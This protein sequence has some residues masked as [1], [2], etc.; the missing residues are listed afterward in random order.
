M[1]TAL[2][3]PSPTC[4]VKYDGVGNIIS[5]PTRTNGTRTLSYFA[6]GQVK[7]ITD[8]NGNDANFRY[9]AFGAVQQLVLTGNTPDTRH[10]Q[11]FGGLIT[12]RDEVVGGTRKSV[13]TRSI[14][15]PGVIATRHGPTA[16]RGRSRSA[17]DA[18][19]A[20]SPTRTAPSFRTSSY[21]PYGE[22]N[23]TGAQPGA[24]TYTSAQWN[25]GDALAA[26]GLSQLGARIYDPVIG[27]FLSRDPLIIPRTAAT[28]NPYAFAMNDPVN[29]SDP[30]GLDFTLPRDPDNP[31]SYRWP[32]PGET[33][34]IHDKRDDLFDPGFDVDKEIYAMTDGLWKLERKRDLSPFYDPTHRWLRADDADE[35]FKKK[36]D[37]VGEAMAQEWEDLARGGGKGR[38][39]R[40]ATGR[41]YGAYSGGGGAGGDSPGGSGGGGPGGGRISV[42]VRQAISGADEEGN[43]IYV[44]PVTRRER[45]REMSAKQRREYERYET[46]LQRENRVKKETNRRQT[47]KGVEEL[48]DKEK[49]IR[50]AHEENRTDK[51]EQRLEEELKRL[52]KDKE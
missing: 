20:S 24:P 49:S 41:T 47:Q 51:T 3:A 12:K 6:N 25:G 13:L 33:I 14:P 2:A 46:K 35:Y 18:A 42:V 36:W 45:M 22:A 26:L 17:K 5:Q 15:G 11:H 23:S 34:E 10:D 28:T 40:G 1:A 9:D 37:E 50:A 48:N 30:S 27:R 44:D 8:G 7:E 39:T 29:G 31:D 21:Q 52:K 16:T 43:V 19:T 4:N 32:G 38:R